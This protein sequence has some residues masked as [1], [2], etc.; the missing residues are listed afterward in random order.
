MLSRLPITLEQLNAGNNAEKLKNEVSQL[1][2]SCTVQ[3]KKLTKTIYNNL[4]NTI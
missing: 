3:K 2:H 4:I 1:L